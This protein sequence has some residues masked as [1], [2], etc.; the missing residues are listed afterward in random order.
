M[1]PRVQVIFITDQ[2]SDMLKTRLALKRRFSS[3]RVALISH[4][5]TTENMTKLETV[6]DAVIVV[7]KSL[8]V[9]VNHLSHVAFSS[10][11]VPVTIEITESDLNAIE[12]AISYYEQKIFNEFLI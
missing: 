9:D 12:E 1:I 11:L 3:E 8:V 2:I 7:P 10:T 6:K 5:L 4:I